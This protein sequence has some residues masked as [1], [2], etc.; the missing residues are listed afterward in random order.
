MTRPKPKH[1]AAT[2]RITRNNQH[3]EFA[4]RYQDGDR[5]RFGY[6]RVLRVYHPIRGEE[7]R[8]ELEAGRTMHVKARV[9]KDMTTRTD[10]MAAAMFMPPDVVEELIAT[11][12]GK[13]K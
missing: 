8:L 13:P 4:V 1:D 7:V 10:Q 11:L 12:Q 3:T 9:S 6:L 5:E 2:V